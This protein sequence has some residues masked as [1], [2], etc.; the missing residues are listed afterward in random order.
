[1]MSFERARLQ[2]RRQEYFVEEP[3]FSPA[4]GSQQAVKVFGWR[5]P[6]R[7]AICGDVRDWALAPEV[8]QRLKPQGRPGDAVLI[9]ALK[10]LRHQKEIAMKRLR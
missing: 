8:P 9:A 3:G 5:R 10:A 1:M 6:S 7:P 4:L 2:P